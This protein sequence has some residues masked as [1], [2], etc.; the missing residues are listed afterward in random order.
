M[1][2]TTSFPY[3]TQTDIHLVPARERVYTN[4][5]EDVSG[6]AFVLSVIIAGQLGVFV[7]PVL[8]TVLSI[9]SLG[10]LLGVAAKYRRV[11]KV[12]LAAGS[13]PLLTLVNLTFAQATAFSQT[14]VLYS[15]MLLVSLMYRYTFRKKI[16]EDTRSQLRK[17]FPS[18]LV[19]AISLGILL[20][21]ICFRL[22][23]SGY[24]FG[25][26]PVIWVLSIA[27]LGALAEESFFRGLIQHQAMT[28]MKPV[29]AVI[30]TSLLYVTLAMGHFTFWSLLVGLISTVILSFVYMKKS[31]VLLTTI[32]N[33]V[34][35]IVYVALIAKFV[36]Y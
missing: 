26:T 27:L 16:L 22:L 29:H 4:I 7:Q 10:I 1:D 13:V 17:N 33:I 18:Y 23:A 24:D 35:K 25:A 15:G 3:P 12:I 20:G 36:I 8:G 34:S 30:L 19:Y 28:V 14:I 31:S 9:V 2:N 21:A 5:R 32:M 11:R 6:Y